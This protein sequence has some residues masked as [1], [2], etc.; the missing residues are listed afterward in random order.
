M[1]GEHITRILDYHD[2]I[3]KEKRP[4]TMVK[5]EKMFCPECGKKEVWVYQEGEDFYVGKDHIC[6]SCEHY[7]TIQTYKDMEVD[8]LNFALKELRK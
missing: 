1:S 8:E 2:R 7:F 4:V 6:L 5:E 3:F